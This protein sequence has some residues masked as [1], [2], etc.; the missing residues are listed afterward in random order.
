ME[1]RAALSLRIPSAATPCAMLGP[2]PRPVGLAQR[3]LF[4][5][6]MRALLGPGRAWR[7]TDDCGGVVKHILTLEPPAARSL[8]VARPCSTAEVAAVIGL[9][10]EF[11]VPVVPNCGLG[12]DSTHID[13]GDAGP[14]I[15]LSLARMNCI[16]AIDPINFTVTVEA[17]VTLEALTEALSGEGLALPA[18]IDADRGAQ[19][20]TLI[21]VD[22][23][24]QRARMHDIV[25]TLDVVLPDGKRWEGVDAPAGADSTDHLRHLFCGAHGALGIVTR[26]VLRVAPAPVCRAAVLVAV[27]DLAAAVKI[28][29]LLRIW[30]NDF[31]RSIDFFCE[32]SLASVLAATPARVRPLTTTS[33][34][35]LL[36]E[37]ASCLKTLRW[38]ASS[39]KSWPSPRPT[40]QSWM[41]RSPWMIR[42]SLTGGSCSNLCRNPMTPPGSAPLL[43][44]SWCRWP[45]FRPA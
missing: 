43:V 42:K 23:G 44:P 30:A 13:R 28:A 17:G 39:T 26:A 29:V 7:P 19:I 22:A 36:A 16:E 3:H 10:S 38:P 6:R 14:G 8:G 18:S 35:Y 12:G 2:L 40:A 33:H 25:L 9:C 1:T 27:D 4:G 31:L 15:G 45:S 34:I 21:G 5:E 41:L 37:L 32:D 20:G 24:D 11:G